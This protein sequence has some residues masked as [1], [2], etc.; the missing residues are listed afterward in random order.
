M[1][2]H[3]IQDQ[4]HIHSMYIYTTYKAIHPITFLT[5]NLDPFP[6]SFC[7]LRTYIYMISYSII[8]AVNFK[9]FF[10]KFFKFVFLFIIFIKY[11]HT[12]L[13]VFLFPSFSFSFLFMIFLVVVVFLF[14]STNNKRQRDICYIY[15][16]KPSV[17]TTI[18]SCALLT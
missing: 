4:D 15:K 6:H 5:S 12:Y 2:I 8:M 16:S 1:Y 14:F 13:E 11:L 9:C 7:A 10:C 18:S 17:V 3:K